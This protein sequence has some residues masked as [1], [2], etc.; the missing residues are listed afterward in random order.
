MLGLPKS[1]E[2]D[3]RIPKQKF[4]ENITVSPTLKRFFI[5]Q[6]RVIY[7]RNKIAA[8]TINLAEGEN[9][10]EIEAFEIKLTSPQ[11]DE[12]VLKQIDREI[13][14]HIVFLL[15]YES[16]YQVWTAYKE[17]VASGSNAF[18]VG[19]YYHT[20]WL[21]EQ[22]LYLKLDGLNLDVVYENIVRQVGG[23]TLHSERQESL[24]ESVERENRRKE[25][26]R[27]IEVLQAKIRKEKQLNKQV[28][29]N[30][31]VKKLKAELQSLISI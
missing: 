14:Y 20:D 22:D 8:T 26:L 7:W 19:A 24:K 9:V 25:L 31:D 29:L 1:T 23:D 4:Y 5:D 13:P 10:T 12:S 21:D 18:K 16:K 28:K 17:A 27:Q 30:E 3:R 6:I 15:E 2:F 11:L